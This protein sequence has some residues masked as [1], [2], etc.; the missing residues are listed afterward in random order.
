MS[1]IVAVI[2]SFGLG[3]ATVFGLLTWA[4]ERAAP[5]LLLD[6]PAVLGSIAVEVRGAVARPGTYTLAAGSRYGDAIEAAG[7]FAPDADLASVNVARQ[8]G[9]PAVVDIPAI[10]PTAAATATRVPKSPA[11]R[12]PPTRSALPGLL[13]PVGDHGTAIDINRAGADEL[14]QLPGIG[15]TLAARIVADRE[16]NGPYAT[17]DDL[18]RV[19][20]ISPRMIDEM[21]PMITAP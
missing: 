12:A 13:P 11:T 3:L 16:A 19:K 20:G 1:R 8:I 9:Q 17:V 10:Q 4:D 14:E 2:M 6:Q 5:R 7:G 21:R 15:P 18:A